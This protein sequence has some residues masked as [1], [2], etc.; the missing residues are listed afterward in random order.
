MLNE[1]CEY[2]QLETNIMDS[3]T[4]SKGRTFHHKCIKPALDEMFDLLEQ[5]TETLNKTSE[6][7][8]QTIDTANYWRERTLIANQALDYACQNGPMLNN[9]E[10]WESARDFA[11]KQAEK[12]AKEK[13]IDKPFGYKIIVLGGH[14]NG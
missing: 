7:L 8:K 3:L 5:A 12:K 13:L 6:G 11:F 4:T 1:L 9:F 10:N 2:C 14:D